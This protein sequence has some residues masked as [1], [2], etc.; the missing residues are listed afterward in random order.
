MGKL[1]RDYEDWL[2]KRG[3]D[4]GTV[5]AQI[6]RVGRVE[7]HYGSLDDQYEADG[8]ASVLREL[9]YSTEDERRGLANPSKVVFV[10][11]IRNNL[12]T[13]KSAV[14]RYRR[15]R[16]SCHV[17]ASNEVPLI[18]PARTESAAPLSLLRVQKRATGRPA[19][20][21][22]DGSRTMM[23]FGLDGR[24][25]LEAVVASSQYRTIEQAVASLTLFSHPQTVRQTGGQ[26]LFPS[27]R[28]TSRVGAIDMHGDRRVLMDDNKSPTDAF[29]WANGLTRRGPDT[30]FNHVYGAS[31]DPDAYTSLANLCMTP[32]FIAKLT[33]T[34][35]NIRRLLRYRS[36]QLYQWTPTGY[37]PPER[38]EEYETLEWAAPLPPVADVCSAVLTAM[39]TKPKDRTVLA[40]KQ[41]G[42]LFG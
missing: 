35:K 29:L 6:Y 22:R 28:N 3:Y 1:R 41:L 14:S 27:I 34:N 17:R 40:V 21:P 38:P 4:E 32:A 23:D 5:S 15:F 37:A 16:E 26:A 20:A 33:D 12:A 2:R 18:E 31:L 24:A 11:N 13:Y 8:A 9:T 7:E 25:A 19:P 30:Q 10:G 42:W 39:A 36:Y